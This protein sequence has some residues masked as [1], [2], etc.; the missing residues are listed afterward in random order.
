MTSVVINFILNRLNMETIYRGK[1]NIFILTKYCCL[2]KSDVEGAKVEN[3]ARLTS[4][5]YVSLYCQT[6]I[7]IHQIQLT[8][9]RFHRRIGSYKVISR[10]EYVVGPEMVVKESSNNIYYAKT[11]T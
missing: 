6:D 11:N 9:S 4:Q 8:I 3:H 10:R 1:W 5:S 2:L 7:L